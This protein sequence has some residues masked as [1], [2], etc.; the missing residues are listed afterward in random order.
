MN[1]VDGLVNEFN[2]SG[3]VEG[4][5]YPSQNTTYSAINFRGAIGAGRQN[6]CTQQIRR[7][8]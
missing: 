8:R 4:A 7:N 5:T 2:R 6:A 1:L 3:M